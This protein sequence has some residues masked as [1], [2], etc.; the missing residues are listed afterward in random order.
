MTGPSASAS[1]V[2]RPSASV[3]AKRRR[4]GSP[5]VARTAAPWIARPDSSTSRPPTRRPRGN[6]IRRLS[7]SD[8]GI[9]R[10]SF[11]IVGRREGEKSENVSRA[12]ATAVAPDATRSGAAS[13]EAV[14]RPSAFVSVKMREPY[15]LSFGPGHWTPTRTP[16]RGR[17]AS[18]TTTPF[19]V[20]RLAKRSVTSR[21]APGRAS[22]PV[23]RSVPSSTARR[24]PRNRRPGRSVE[25][26]K[27]G[28]GSASS[29]SPANA[30][31]RSVS[32]SSVRGLSPKALRKSRRTLSGPIGTPV[33]AVTT[34][35]WMRAMPAF[36]SSAAGVGA[37]ASGATGSRRR[38]GAG[39]SPG[40]A[41]GG[42][43]AGPGT[44]AGVASGDGL[45]DRG[46]N[47]TSAASPNTATP[48]APSAR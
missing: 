4:D 11:A 23:V 19:Q 17:P 32:T 36:A 46:R 48:T 18:S 2:K 7:R 29:N 15:G 5:Y 9:V 6:T 28:I 1:S 35:P 27:S 44:A 47:A 24:K 8:A 43:A 21:I 30:P 38:V 3:F 12:A 39:A 25:P 20:A 10:R 42:G 37:A 41:S 33:S 13:A 16:R 26:S 14:N 22:T 45:G 34:V 31:K 40:A